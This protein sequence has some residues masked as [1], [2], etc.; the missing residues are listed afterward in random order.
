MLGL[1]ASRL[2]NSAEEMEREVLV[3]RLVSV[4][5]NDEALAGADL[6]VT[7]RIGSEARR[8]AVNN[9]DMQ[10][11]LTWDIGASADLFVALY[12]KRVVGSV[13]LG[14][15]GPIP[16]L[17]LGVF[18]APFLQRF[19]LTNKDGKRIGK[20]QLE[21]SLAPSDDERA[22]R[23]ARLHAA[24]LHRLIDLCKDPLPAT[25]LLREPSATSLS[26]SP[27]GGG[28][29]SFND[30]DA[31]EFVEG[32]LSPE[33]AT[34]FLQSDR[35]GPLFDWV[36]GAS[37][38]QVDEAI[39]EVQKSFKRIVD[40]GP[41]AIDRLV[42][43]FYARANLGTSALKSIF[44]RLSA[45]ARASSAVEIVMAVV[46]HLRTPNGLGA[47][48]IKKLSMQHTEFG[49]TV[50]MVGALSFLFAFAD[51]LFPCS[52]MTWDARCWRECDPP[53]WPRAPS[54]PR[55]WMRRGASPTR[56]SRPP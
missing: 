41:V 30:K 24:L 28:L 43:A 44:G 53:K 21:L 26:P 15:C 38:R 36:L 7:L 45:E 4:E 50:D 9:M 47:D 31:D 55:C 17:E 6:A 11:R 51:L 48:R 18:K 37:Q 49:V 20:I 16:A 29:G 27:R 8:V 19:Q 54:G 46:S 13:L 39:S 1:T 42:E 10:Q 2:R 3:V 35:T 34:I 22:T 52:T 32:Y 40:G 14:S 23:I 56:S 33:D 12:R 25:G 5:L